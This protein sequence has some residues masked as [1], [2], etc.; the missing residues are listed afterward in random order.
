[1][2]GFMGVFR[3]L[4]VLVVLGAVGWADDSFSSEPC[5]SITAIDA[6]AGTVTAR[7]IGSKRTF[8]FQVSDAALL[9]SL[10][11]GQAIAADFKTRKVSVDPQEPCCSI[12][13][14]SQ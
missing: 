5:C 7:E 10:R 9:R 6:K 13:N 1:M 2:L 14:V 4:A 3:L 12:V 11:V 8:Q